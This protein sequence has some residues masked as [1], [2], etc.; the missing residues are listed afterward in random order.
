MKQVICYLYEYENNRQVRNVGFIKG[1]A[2]QEKVIFQ[3]HGKGLDCARDRNLKMY[4]FSTKEGVSEISEVGY[5]E[6]DSRIVNYKMTVEPMSIVQLEQYD[7]I[8]L[9]SMGEK[10]YVATWNRSELI[11]TEGSA[12][13]VQIQ[14]DVEAQP[15]IEE[16]I[17]EE[18]IIEEAI[19]EEVDAYMNQVEAEISEEI[20][21][22]LEQE[23]VQEIKDEV[24]E[25]AIEESDAVESTEEVI[26]YEKIDRQGLSVLP[27]RE[28]R[29]AN[30][31]FLLHGYYNYK[32]LLFIRE[33]N[34][35]YLGVPGV[36][37]AKEEEAAK[38]FGFPAFHRVEEGKLELQTN[39]WNSEADFGYWCRQVALRS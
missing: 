34:R 9:Q 2:V 35:L 24:T 6:G 5:V 31:S 23:A 18:A 21:I 29:V 30:N 7:G 8:Y 12:A 1:M 16:E 10:R 26:T 3:I 32:H 20:S 4:L 11:L 28:W 33:D 17:I 15:E 39:E 22:P 25:G 37:H 27:Q 38:S 36:Y 13:Q 14:E 19:I